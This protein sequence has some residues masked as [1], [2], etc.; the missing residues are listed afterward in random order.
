MLIVTDSERYTDDRITKYH[1]TQHSFDQNEINKIIACIYHSYT[2]VT[3]TNHCYT[4]IRQDYNSMCIDNLNAVLKYGKCFEYKM[5]DNRRLYRLAI[6]M[7]HKYFDIIYIIEPTYY[8]GGIYLKLIT[9]YTNAKND[10]HSTLDI[11]NY[12]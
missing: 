8:K 11:K 6:K 4:E 9:C 1:I 5:I 10:R 2:Y 3:I 7:Y 12:A